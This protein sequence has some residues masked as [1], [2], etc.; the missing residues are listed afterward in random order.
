MRFATRY[1]VTIARPVDE[2]FAVLATSEHVERVVRL[3]PILTSF[4]LRDVRAGEVAG[5]EVVDFDFS[6]HVPL[7]PGCSSE[8][9]IRVEQTVDR[10]ALRVDYRSITKQPPRLTIHKVRTFEPTQDGGT[11]VAEVITG[12]T[13]PGLHLLARRSAT[14]AHVVHMDA[15][16]TLFA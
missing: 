11:R 2:V 15:Y 12:D 3:S 4:T 16:V 10:A 6:E 1:A 8:V 7:L 9:A 5:A 14:R 13:L